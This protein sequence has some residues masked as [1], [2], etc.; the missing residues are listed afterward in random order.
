[1]IRSPTSKQEKTRQRRRSF[2]VRM[3]SDQIRLF[4]FGHQRS[5]NFSKLLRTSGLRFQD[6]V[7]RI[8]GS[9]FIELVHARTRQSR[10][11]RRTKTTKK[12][13]RDWILGVRS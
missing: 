10:R 4:C 8:W 5:R 3:K 1:M 12:V 9:G 13:P 2:V 11:N 7:F 6:S